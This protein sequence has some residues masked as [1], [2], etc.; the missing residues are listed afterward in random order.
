MAKLT[1]VR[2]RVHQPFRDTL[3]RTSGLYPSAVQDRTDLFTKAGKNDA[4][5]NLKNGST[6]PS[7]Q[8]MVVLALRVF[9][10]FRAS[11]LRPFPVCCDF[12]PGPSVASPAGGSS[13][14]EQQ[15]L[16]AARPD[17]PCTS[18][19]LLCNGDIQPTADCN[20]LAPILNG[21]AIGNYE[22]VYRLHW[23]AEEQLLW[24]FGSGQ[25][26]S[27]TSMPT[28]YFPYGGGIYGDM[29][30]AGTACCAAIV[31]ESTGSPS[32][33]PVIRGLGGCC[34]GSVIGVSVELSES[35]GSYV[36]TVEGKGIA[37]FTATIP[38]SS[39]PITFQVG[40]DGGDPCL[41]ITLYAPTP[42]IAP[43]SGPLY[44]YLYEIRRDCSCGPLIHWENGTPD[45][46]GILRLARAILLPPRQN[47]LCQAQIVRLPDGGNAG[48]FGSTQGSRDMLSLTGNLNAVDALQKVISFTFDGLFSRD[49]Q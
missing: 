49:V 42:G 23:Q 2:E 5:S 9:T 46:S 41:E 43:I 3:I 14:N 10:W 13:L 33:P 32:A 1:N 22:D 36:V 12:R 27:L 28:A 8:S 45:H 34:A 40:P 21:S 11:Q 15:I 35:P 48:T 26:F 6:L 25:K 39:F 29:G 30:H 24:S 37:S 19:V 16:I 47:V 17:G 18:T 20:T 4:E 31:L 44:A 38:A 7:D